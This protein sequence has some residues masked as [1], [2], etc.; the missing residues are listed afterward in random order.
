MGVETWTG[1]GMVRGEVGYTVLFELHTKNGCI[2]M[3][4]LLLPY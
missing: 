1:E 4:E 3:F 2:L